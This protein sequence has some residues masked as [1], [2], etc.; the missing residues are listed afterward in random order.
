MGAG[1]TPTGNCTS[2]PAGTHRQARRR[3]TSPTPNQP[4]TIYFTDMVI[5]LQQHRHLYFPQA[6]DNNVRSNE[7]L[8]HHKLYCN[9]LFGALPKTPGDISCEG[10]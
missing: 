2:E 8:A 1:A 7:P 4:P 9:G 6:V 5:G 3:A 10:R